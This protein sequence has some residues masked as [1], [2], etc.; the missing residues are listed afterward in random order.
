MNYQL[1]HLFR[2]VL[3]GGIQGSPEAQDGDVVVQVDNLKEGTDLLH[4]HLQNLVR[5]VWGLQVSS[6]TNVVRCGPKSIS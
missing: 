1:S 4:L 3:D 6:H 5:A 2:P